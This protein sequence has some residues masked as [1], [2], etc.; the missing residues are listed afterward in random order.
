LALRLRGAKT[1]FRLGPQLGIQRGQA[2]VRL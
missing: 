2:F 1:A